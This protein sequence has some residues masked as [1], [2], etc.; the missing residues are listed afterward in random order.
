MP[1]RPGKVTYADEDDLIARCFAANI[2]GAIDASAEDLLLR[3][4]QSPVDFAAVK[5]VYEE[6][7]GGD[8]GPLIKDTFSEHDDVIEYLLVKTGLMDTGLVVVADEFGQS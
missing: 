1:E 7:Y 2:K 6:S 4:L 3:Y 8:P 5:A